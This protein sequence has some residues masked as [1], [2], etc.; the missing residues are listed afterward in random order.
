MALS[1]FYS[2]MASFIKRMYQQPENYMRKLPIH[3]IFAVTES[4]TIGDNNTL[5]WKIPGD[6]KYFKQQTLGDIVIMG[7]KTWESLPSAPLPGRLNIIV[8][9]NEKFK[10]GTS[11]KIADSIDRAIELANIYGPKEAPDAKAIWCIGGAELYEKMQWLADKAYVTVIHDHYVGDTIFQ[12]KRE[13]K[14]QEAGAATEK[15]DVVFT[16]R[17][18]EGQALTEVTKNVGI[19]RVVIDFNAVPVC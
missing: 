16:K 7:R 8:T 13:G 4:G 2:S 12:M 10:T 6:L 17:L 15:L 18:L 1:C 14:P 5:P 19:S 9:R 3:L 11:T